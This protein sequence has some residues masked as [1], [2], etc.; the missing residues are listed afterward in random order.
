MKT[1]ILLSAIIFIL[2][3]TIDFAQEKISAKDAANYIDKS[4]TVIDTVTGVYLSKSGTY[5]INMGGDYPDNAF[6]AVI[7]K[8]DTSKFHNVESLEG[9]V[10]EV[11]GKVKEYREKPEIVVEKVKQVRV[12]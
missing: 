1:K 12:E 3:F 4:V 10:V 7:F 9:K 5:F 11:T 8:S 2:I 6:T